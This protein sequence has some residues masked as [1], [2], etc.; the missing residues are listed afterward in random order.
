VIFF[1][2]IG[3][4]SA[5]GTALIYGMGGYLVIQDVFTIG[6]IVAFGSYLTSLYNTRCGAGQ[7][8]GRVCH[9]AGQL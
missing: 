7:R 2:I 8:P 6:T 9:L 1:V 5:I 4:I 3:M